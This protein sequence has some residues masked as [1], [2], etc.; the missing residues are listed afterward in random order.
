[1]KIELTRGQLLRRLVL[2]QEDVEQLYK[3]LDTTDIDTS[4]ELLNGCSIDTHLT[5]ILVV[6][7]VDEYGYIDTSRNYEADRVEKEWTTKKER[8]INGS[9]RLDF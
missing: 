1:M 6:T 5:N 4:K 8:V 9:S 7:D 2:I 3:A